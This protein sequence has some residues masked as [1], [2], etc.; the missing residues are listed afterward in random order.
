MENGEFVRKAIGIAIKNVEEGG[1][2]FGAVVVKD[3]RVIATSG[4][5]VTLL[6]DPTAH[7]EVLAIREAAS[8]LGTWDLSGCVLYTS[9]EPCPMCFGAIYWAHLDKV[10]YA[11][12]HEDAK[13]AGFDDS[14]I[15]S[16][17]K[18]DPS[19]RTIEM[20]QVMRDEGLK[21]FQKWKEHPGKEEY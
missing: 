9:C 6:N 1:G 12:T 20:E 15:Y 19:H 21:A 7:A 13:D 2:P 4:N 18:K 5:K 16:E 3:G 8:R 10:H 11:C 17:L 14:H